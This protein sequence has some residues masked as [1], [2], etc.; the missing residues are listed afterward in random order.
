MAKPWGLGA[1]GSKT[2]VEEDE[3]VAFVRD[4]KADMARFPRLL[5]YLYYDSKDSAITPGAMQIAYEEFLGADA[6]TMNDGGAP[7]PAG[8][9]TVAGARSRRL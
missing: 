4:A 8:A 7:P 1:F 6:F 3:R 5:A 2:D 9:L